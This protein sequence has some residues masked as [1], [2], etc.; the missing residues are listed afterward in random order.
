MEL[1]F[2]PTPNGWKISIMLEE[3]GVPYD[4]KPVN[5]NKGEQFDP[6]FQKIA[7]NNR[8]PVITDPEGPDGQPISV[9]ESGA[10]LQYLGRKFDRFYPVDERSRVDVEEWLM[11]QMGGFGPM[12]GQ[13][14]HFRNAAAEPFPYGVARYSRETERLYDV[15]NRRLEGRKYVAAGQFTIADIAILGWV[16]R[17]PRHKTDLN[18]FPNVKVWYERLLDRPTVQR[19]F[20]AG[21]GW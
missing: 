21:E 19:G 5:I 3:L 20:A 13:N 8:M 14:H 11:W 6:V 12:L 10:I 15:L 1:Y 4:L 7:P 16:R 17:W 18:E 2:W 9:F